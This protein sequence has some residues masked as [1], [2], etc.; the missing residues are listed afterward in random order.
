MTW[1]ILDHTADIGIRVE[2]DSLAGAFAE[3]AEAMF[4][5]MIE[6]ERKT[7]EERR[8]E[9]SSPA[10]DMLLVDFLSELLFLFETE[11]FVVSRAEVSLEEREGKWSL[12]ARLLGELFDPDRHGVNFEIKAVTYHMLEAVESLEGGRVQVLFDI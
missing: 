9:M 2:A 8:L 10:V 3:A 5:I 7:L 6:G 11:Y 1:E 12:S 4:H